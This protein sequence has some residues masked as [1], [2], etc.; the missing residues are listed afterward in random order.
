MLNRFHGKT[1]TSQIAQVVE[2]LID[3]FKTPIE[4]I[5]KRTGLK[6]DYIEKMLVVSRIHPEV[7]EA[8]D[9]ERIGVCH[10]YQLGRITDKDVQLRLFISCKQY[11][12]KVAD[13]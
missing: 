2:E 10:A 11:D 8:L 6:R 3:K 7:L 5:E 9:E 4:E 1:K 13:S 12:M